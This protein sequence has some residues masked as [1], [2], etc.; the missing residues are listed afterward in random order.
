M[1]VIMEE[2]KVMAV[3]DGNTFE[4]S[5]DWEFDGQRGNMVRAKGYEAPRYG[6]E[7]MKM[8]Q[9]LSILIMNKKVA[10]GMPDGIEK[11][12]L[13]CE[14]YFDGRNIADYFTQYK[15]RLEEDEEEEQE[16]EE[17]IGEEEGDGED[18]GFAEDSE[19]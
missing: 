19:D 18:E 15:E 8:E 2:F 16:E 7:A 1:N 9:N 10:L 12:N 4:V 6:K 3:I 11:G 17:V 5:P 13:V 14:V